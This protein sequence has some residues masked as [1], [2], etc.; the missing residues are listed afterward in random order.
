MS[1]CDCK[2]TYSSCNTNKFSH[3]LHESFA[4]SLYR[5]INGPTIYSSSFFHLYQHY[6]NWAIPV[7]EVMCFTTGHAHMLVLLYIFKL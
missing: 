7:F 6:F 4:L 3:H 2:K 5:T 1:A